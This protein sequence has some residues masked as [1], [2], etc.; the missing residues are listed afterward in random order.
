M[1]F[2][3]QLQTMNKEYVS[4]GK[5]VGNI[6]LPHSF[7]HS[8]V[9]HSESQDFPFSLMGNSLL[10]W[11]CVLNKKELASPYP[12]ISAISTCHLIKILNH[13]L[14]WKKKPNNMHVFQ[15]DEV[16]MFFCFLWCLNVHILNAHL[17]WNCTCY[18]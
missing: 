14:Y 13:C 12:W 15:F 4:C 3:H 17:Q 2:I 11:C 16:K 8:L 10:K 18:L 5:T 6:Y 7:S 1:N 9:Q